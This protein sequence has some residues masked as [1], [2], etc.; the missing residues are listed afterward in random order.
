[1]PARDEACP[2]KG[3][4]GPYCTSQSCLILVT[5]ATAGIRGCDEGGAPLTRLVI[6]IIH[7]NEP[8][9]GGLGG[10]GRSS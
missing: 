2:E 1:M 8:G 4:E 3:P 5:T 7:V 9:K 10:G 6:C